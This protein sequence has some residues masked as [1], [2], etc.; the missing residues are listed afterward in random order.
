MKSQ[1]AQIFETGLTCNG[2]SLLNDF[3]QI[4]DESRKDY[5]E[6]GEAVGDMEDKAL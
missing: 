6:K 3:M 2:K 4:C 5:K 1:N